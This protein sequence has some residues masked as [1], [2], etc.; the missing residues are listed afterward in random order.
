MQAIILAAGFGSRLAPMTLHKPKPLLEIR[1]KSILEN[2]INILKMSGVKDI[3]VVTGYKHWLFDSLAKSLC[4]E[5]IVFENYANCNSSQS[6]LYVQD[7][8]QKG[9]IILNGDLYIENDFCKF[10]KSG[11]SQF[12]AQKIPS[13]TSAW[14]YIIDENYRILDIDINATSGYGDGIAYFDNEKEIIIFKE[15]LAQCKHDEY[16]EY[17]VLKSLDSI[18]YYAFYYN[19]LY[20]EIDSFADALRHRLLTPEEIAM[21]CADDKRAIRLAGITNINYLIKFQGEQKVIRIPGNG[22][23]NVIDRK[24]E[25]DII[26]LVQD[27][28]ITPKSEFY[29][30]GIKMSDFLSDYK[31]LEKSQI[32]EEILE[33][34]ADSLL[35][36][37]SI[38]HTSHKNYKIIKLYDEIIKY[39]NLAKI[40]LATPKE[41]K[42]VIEVAKK[43]D[44][45]TD[46]VLCHRDL[47]LPNI[48]FNGSAIQLVD[49]EYA[50]FSCI[51]WEFGNMAAELELSTEQIEYLIG[52]YNQH[53]AK[54]ISFQEV[55][56]GSLMANYIWA[57]WGWIYGR[58]DLGREYLFRFQDNLLTL[59]NQEL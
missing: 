54:H 33:K 27:L 1:G 48:L 42:Y 49:F 25:Q 24:G 40:S 37:H 30:S 57:L 19:N 18:Q 50:G 52:Y 38:K 2:M 10:F 36:L 5:K 7:R 51:E 35:K 32:T 6:L 23:E 55:I 16:W 15:Q 21:Q 22:T 9:T 58:I 41:H 28:G 26:N 56:E 43:L 34:I 45:D 20:T 17:A 44:S 59:Q 47:Q 3:I 13:N 4:F 14:G 46:M 12:L 31:S 29:G 53:S 39:E 8:I 11:V